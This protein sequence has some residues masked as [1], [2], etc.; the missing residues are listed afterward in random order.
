M[1]MLRRGFRTM[2]WRSGFADFWVWRKTKTKRRVD[3]CWYELLGVIFVEGD[4]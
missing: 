4:Q 3:V 2:I 1:G